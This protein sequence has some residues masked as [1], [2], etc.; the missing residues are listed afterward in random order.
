MDDDVDGAFGYKQLVE[1]YVSATAASELESIWRGDRYVLLSKGK[2]H[3]MV[4]ESA[5]AKASDARAALRTIAD[6]LHTRFHKPIRSA[7]GNVWSGS[8]GQVAGLHRYGNTVV[9][10]YAPSTRQLMGLLR[11]RPR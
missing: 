8:P 3:A 4:F 1:R 9:L 2:D 10:A 7:H 11:Q 5:Y 6:S